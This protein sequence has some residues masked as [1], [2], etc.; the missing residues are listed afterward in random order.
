MNASSTNRIF[1]AMQSQSL[2]RSSTALQ[3]LPSSQHSF[4]RRMLE[5][6]AGLPALSALREE[7]EAA[8]SDAWFGRRLLDVMQ[9][10]VRI[11]PCEPD[12]PL[13]GPVVVTSNH[14]FGAVEGLALLDALRACRRDVKVLAN[15]VLQAVPEMAEHCFYVDPFGG[16]EATERNLLPVARAMRWLRAG[17]VLLVFPAGE[18]ASL[19]ICK[20]RVV[21]APWLPLIGGL[22]HRAEAKVVPVFVPGS[23]R[24]PFHVAGL[25]HPRLRTLLLGREFLAQRGKTVE[26]RFGKPI[27]YAKL[28]DIESP[29]DLTAYLRRRSLVMALAS[30]AKPADASSRTLASGEESVAKPAAVNIVT[31]EI[32]GLP[33]DQ[34]LVQARGFRV[35]HARSRQIPCTLHEIGRLRELTFRSAGEGT[36]HSLDLDRFDL[37]Y[38]HLVVWNE[39]NREVVGAYRMGRTDH[40]VPEQG[41]AGLYCSTLFRVRYG[42]LD[43][44]GPSLELGRSFVRAEYQSNPTAIRLLWKGIGHYVVKH[45]QYR[46]LFGPVSIS[47]SYT[48]ASRRL[49]VAFLQEHASATDLAHYI[50]PLR[51]IPSRGTE[52]FR[53]GRGIF[54]CSV[55]E[56]SCLVAD[57]EPDRKGLPPLLRQYV[58][59]GGRFAGFNLDPDFCNVVDGLVVVDL[60]ATERSVLASYMTE[61][62]LHSFLQYPGY[63]RG[64]QAAPGNWNPGVREPCPAR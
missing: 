30:I 23:N 25:V 55:E 35:V 9:V 41:L 29:H 37:R 40:I 4:Q 14:P 16:K 6:V 63:R 31:R 7:L 53:R 34:V 39:R 2:A 48:E 22:I 47:D 20:Q 10:D 15:G 44:L 33:L 49:I 52:P 58:R 3:I 45:P 42:F 8:A 54:R 46:A 17:H 60:E 28:R 51:A 11:T 38:V 26:L 59:L 32:E 64:T 50:R 21:E 19:S 62:G 24:W 5:S 61:P 27:S 43:R 18:V 57:L 13:E 36:G 1:P 12:V 56:L